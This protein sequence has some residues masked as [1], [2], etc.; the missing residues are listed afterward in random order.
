MMNIA[1]I[2]LV[3]IK[4]VCGVYSPPSNDGTLSFLA[5]GDWGGQSSS[6]Y[7][8]TDEVA[9][10]NQ[11][12]DI[13]KKINSTFVMALGDN[14]YTFGIRTDA[15]DKRFKETFEDVFTAKSLQTP[16]YVV[17]GNHDWRG[18]VTAEVEYT[19]LSDRWTFPSLYYTF[20]Y[21]I[22]GTKTTIAFIMIDTQVLCGV[23][24]EFS[25]PEELAGPQD[26][27][28]ADKE[29]HWIEQQL[30]ATQSADYVIVAGHY[31]VWS[32]GEHGPTE[33]LVSRLRPLLIK[34]KVNAYFCGHDHNLQHLREDSS[35]VE[36]FV[37]GAGHVVNT[38][39][40]H[41][42]SVPHN[43][44]KF[45]YAQDSSL[46]GFAYIEATPQSMRLIF[47]DGLAGQ[48]LYSGEIKPRSKL[49][50]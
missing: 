40:V 6:P 14:F 46:G 18:N 50:H 49:H 11:M 3:C 7:A 35:T 41:K 38:S 9:C 23:L 2:L 27:N 25:T 10:A 31:P 44:L 20:N 28:A 30:Q 8:T 16:W 29:W 43:S 21:N 48:D 42:D 36:Y 39:Q 22:P 33:C 4:L 15:H 19:K 13:A 5:L 45:Y 47:A 37:I 12:G 34:Y 1:V 17:A 24:D 26:K 32:I